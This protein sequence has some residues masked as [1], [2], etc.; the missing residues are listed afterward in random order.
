VA[1]QRILLPPFRN[2]TT[3][4]SP[5][6]AKNLNRKTPPLPCSPTP[7]RGSL[8]RLHRA[9]SPPPMIA[10]AKVGLWPKAALRGIAWRMVLDSLSK[11]GWHQ[12]SWVDRGVP[13][14]RRGFNWGRRRQERRLEGSQSSRT[15]SCSVVEEG[16][17][18]S[19]R[20]AHSLLT[21]IEEMR[22]DYSP[23]VQ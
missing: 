6:T 15:F 23:L 3:K 11:G 21:K 17:T 8:P 5:T 19:H 9:L 20:E 14:Q 12:S 13:Q 1:R 22:C 2:P 10:N 18:S 4:P 7:S 16:R